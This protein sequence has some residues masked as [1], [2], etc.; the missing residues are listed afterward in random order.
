MWKWNIQE[1]SRFKDSFNNKK[2]V[3]IATDKGFDDPEEVKEQL[4]RCEVM[5]RSVVEVVLLEFSFPVGIST[6]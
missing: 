1:L 4:S 3:F 6:M 2:I 5:R